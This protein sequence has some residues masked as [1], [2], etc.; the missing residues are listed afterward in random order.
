M[1]KTYWRRAVAVN[2][3]ATDRPTLAAWFRAAEPTLPR[4]PF[5]LFPWI[6]VSDPERAYAGGASVLDGRRRHDGRHLSRPGAAAGV[7]PR[8]RSTAVRLTG[9][10]WL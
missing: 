1:P 5:E 10:G 7:V 3:G 6:L 8:C 2:N 4:E 9:R